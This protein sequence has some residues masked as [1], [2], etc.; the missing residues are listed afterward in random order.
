MTLELPIADSKK[1]FKLRRMDAVLCIGI[2]YVDRRRY[3][4]L[5]HQTEDEEVLQLLHRV[6]RFNRGRGEWRELNPMLVIAL[7]DKIPTL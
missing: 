1:S 7:A 6:S 5:S 3:A 2:T 4:V